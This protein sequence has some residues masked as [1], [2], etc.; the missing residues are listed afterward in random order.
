MVNK[1]LS[2]EEGVRKGKETDKEERVKTVKTFVVKLEIT[3]P[4]KI[5]SASLLEEKYFLSRQKVKE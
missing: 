4:K 3:N 1:T 2:V 5:L